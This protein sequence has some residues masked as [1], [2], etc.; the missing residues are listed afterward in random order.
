MQKLLESLGLTQGEADIYLT[1]LKLGNTTTGAIIR[2]SHVSR[3]KVYEVLD[4]LFK[5]GLVTKMIHNNVQHFEATTPQRLLD[6]LDIVQSDLDCKRKGTLDLIPRLLALQQSHLEK[7]EARIYVGLGGWKSLYAEILE[8][9]QCGDEY[10]AFGIG[11]KELRNK[12][13]QLFFRQFHMKRAKKGVKARLIMH[14]KTRPLM[15]EYFSDLKLLQYRFLDT[16]FPT[17]INVHGNSV[18]TLVWDLHPVAFLIQSKQVATKY[19]SYFV[20]L[21]KEAKKV[22]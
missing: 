16:S 1:L 13:V 9:L 11:S 8:N 4:R 2:E 15:R 10:L 5:K 12:S 22:C 18:V 7:Q 6:M 14:P 19:R 3:S 20:S 17:N 21:W